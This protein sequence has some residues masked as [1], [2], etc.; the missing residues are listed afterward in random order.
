MFPCWKG[1]KGPPQRKETPAVFHVDDALA[2]SRFVSVAEAVD[3]ARQDF[4]RPD[5]PL[6]MLDRVERTAADCPYRRPSQIYACLV[7]LH[8]VAEQWRENHGVLGNQGWRAALA[9]EGI[10]YH[11]RISQT[12]RRRCGDL[13]RFRYRGQWLL[14]QE[15]ATFGA[16]GCNTCASIHWIRDPQRLVV[17]VGHCGRHLPTRLK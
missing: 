4:I 5:G 11:A 13:Y 1:A 14:F 3:A 15:H 2:T 9:R 8:R 6:V 7:A 16:R 17:V 12:A 10:A